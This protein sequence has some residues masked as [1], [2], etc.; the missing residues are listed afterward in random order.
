MPKSTNVVWRGYQGEFS[1]FNITPT[2]GGDVLPFTAGGVLNIGDAVIL[3]ASGTVNKSTANLSQ[4]IGVVVGGNSWSDY[5]YSE[6][7]DGNAAAIIGVA[8]ACTSGGLVYVCVRGVMKVLTDAVVA[9]GA[10]VKLSS[11]TAGQVTTAAGLTIAAGATPVTSTGA[12]GAIISGDGANT[13]MG[14][15]IGAASSGAGGIATI[16]IF[17]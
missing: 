5:I 13:I 15:N 17:G 3:S 12:N 1:D 7:T 16:Y 9:V 4:V 6:E 8:A 14:L 2:I 11:G 10:L